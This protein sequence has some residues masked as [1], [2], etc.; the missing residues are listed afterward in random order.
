MFHGIANGI[1]GC[2]KFIDGFLHGSTTIAVL[3]TFGK[4]IVTILLLIPGD[5]HYG[6]CT[7]QKRKS[8]CEPC[9]SLFI[10][11]L[12]HHPYYILFFAKNQRYMSCIPPFFIQNY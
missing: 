8:F 7:G 10:H 11:S 12:L 2:L 9:S 3:E 1:N 6:D 5:F 4:I